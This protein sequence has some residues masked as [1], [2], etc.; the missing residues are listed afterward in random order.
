MT[1]NVLILG[2]LMSVM[3]V[4]LRFFDTGIGLLAAFLLI[5]FGAFHQKAYGAFMPLRQ[6]EEE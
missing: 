4:D 2:L 1:A 5:Y 3:F 6:Y